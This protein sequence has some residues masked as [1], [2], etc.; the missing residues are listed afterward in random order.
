[1]RSK[2]WKSLGGAL[3]A[4]LGGLAFAGCGRGEARDPSD[5]PALVLGIALADPLGT[6]G[7]GAVPVTVTLENAGPGPALASVRLLVNRPDG[8][9]EVTFKMLG[10]DLREVPFTS[11]V[12]ASYESRRWKVLEPGKSVFATTNLARDYDLSAQG[13]YTVQAVYENS[14]SAPAGT[15]D[16]QAWK[17]RIASPVLRFE[18]K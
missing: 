7:P 2:A 5:P 9:H 15:S 6:T 11:R 17:G 13:F 1:M 14:Q 16:L 3:V 12:N 8:A 4:S 18:R 10:P